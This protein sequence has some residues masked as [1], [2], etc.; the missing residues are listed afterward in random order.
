MSSPEYLFVYGT[1]RSIFG[2]P[3]HRELVGRAHATGTGWVTGKLFDTGRYPA[4]VLTASPDERVHG[5]L[6]T[7]KPELTSELLDL[8]D[9]YEGYYPESPERSLFLRQRVQVTQENGE[10]VP[11]WIYVYNGATD[12]LRRITSGNY[13]ERYQGRDSP[14]PGAPGPPPTS[15]PRSPRS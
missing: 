13:A 6:Y 4:A 14:P 5:E 10:T 3:M 2:G 12:R 8:L 1:L 9:C 7:I 11:A 15:P